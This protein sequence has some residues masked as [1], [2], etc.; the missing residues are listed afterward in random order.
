MRKAS[1]LKFNPIKFNMCS[2]VGSIG[3]ETL[4]KFFRSS[5][6]QNICYCIRDIAKTVNEISDDLGVSPV[7]VESEI[8]HL[9]KYGYLIKQKD[10][11][12]INF[13]IDIPTSKLLNIQNKMYRKAAKLFANDLYDILLS[14]E[15][16]K[17][18]SII[19]PET[20][21]ERDINFLLWT[22]IP[23]ITA[24]SGENIRDNKISFDEVATVRADGAKNICQVTIDPGNLIVP[25]DYVQTKNWCGP[26]NHN[27]DN[28]TYWT[29]DSN[30]SERRL[31]VNPYDFEKQRRVLNLY[32]KSKITP[33]GKDDC[34]WLAENGYIKM[35]NN[36]VP[37]WQ[38]VILDNINI[39]NKLLSIGTS[40]KEKLLKEF[41]EIKLPYA[42]E[43][44][45]C[46][47]KHMKKI[48]EYQMQFTFHCDGNFILYCINELLENG[49]LK[50]PTDDQRKSLS[51]LITPNDN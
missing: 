38:I 51:I 36:E 44:Y 42:E 37:V 13:I 23:Y 24:I 41:N 32:E 50:E 49:K 26:A 18:N 15:I 6:S 45:N 4:D 28:Y 31:H 30:W 40:V 27:N 3:T 19:S 1:D 2:I 48:A 34:T 25:S 33:L 12:I 39:K 16:L 10:K 47:P 22:M 17:S 43:Y 20:N 5:L 46:I 29:V 7:Y 9:E 11:Y 35:D 21:G 14:S 8:E